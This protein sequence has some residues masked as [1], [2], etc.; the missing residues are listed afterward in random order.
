MLH[1]TT[2][3]RFT[4][5]AQVLFVWFVMC[6][7][8]RQQ[9][10][11]A[12]PDNEISD[13]DRMVLETL[14][15]AHVQFRQRPVSGHIRATRANYSPAPVDEL[16]IDVYWSG[17]LYKGTV[18]R[19]VWHDEAVAKQLGTDLG[20][21]KVIRIAG[22]DCR[23]EAQRNLLEP[24]SPLHIS[25]GD[26]PGFNPKEGMT[27]EHVEPDNAWF[28][29]A[30]GSKRDVDWRLSRY[31]Q[32]DYQHSVTTST[33]DM[34][35]VTVTVA[36]MEEGGAT[37]RF[38]MSRGGRIVEGHSWSAK[39]PRPYSAQSSWEWVEDGAGDWRLARQEFTLG[40]RVD[41]P[42]EQRTRETLTIHECSFNIEFPA[43]FFSCGQIEIPAGSI[44]HDFERGAKTPKRSL[45]GQDGSQAQSVTPESLKSL[46]NMLKSSG[47]GSQ[48]KGK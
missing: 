23:I 35:F 37:M 45:A 3:P 15:D 33:D 8:L 36:R 14:R 20:R 47:F 28:R 29:V 9:Q 17:D 32:P 7:D 43:D 25:R 12:G 48:K 11:Q 46:G 6:S 24:D 22:P 41:T 31:L 27:V 1:S 44:I 40:D 39:G 4:R 34:G 26:V 2:S 21:W 10:A 38:D 16:E 42:A 19:Q 30:A 5:I 18:T 13:A